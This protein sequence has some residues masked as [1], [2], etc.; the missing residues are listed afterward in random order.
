[1]KI[2]FTK[3]HGLGNDFMV[4]DMTQNPKMLIN[5]QQIAMLSDRRYGVGFDQMLL[6]ESSEI[7]DFAYRIINADGSEVAQC[8]NGA[9]CFARFVA[10]KGLTSNN[11]ITV[12]THSGLMS[13]F[14]NEDNTVRV[15]MGKIS[16]IDTRTLLP[17]REQEYQGLGSCMLSVGNPH[18]VKIESDI[19]NINIKSTAEEIQSSGLFPEG[20]NVGFMQIDTKCR[21]VVEL[22]VYERGSGETLACGSGACAAIACGVNRG[23]LDSKVRVN[24]KQGSVQVEYKKGEH[25]FLSGEAEFVYEGQ[26]EI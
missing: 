10:E 23:Y 26:I 18:L 21:D 6:V 3:M 25:I 20:I 22:R 11:P 24:F 13:L 8:G 19:W 9:R 15:D 7:A 4:I 16:P 12:E 14:I 17:N 2:N 1:M 5:V